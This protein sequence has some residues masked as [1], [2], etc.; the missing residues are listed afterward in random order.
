MMRLV[1]DGLSV[2]DANGRLL[3][4]P[5]D[6][7]VA[8]GS[9]VSLI[10]ESGAGKS[11]FCAAIAGLLPPELR[12]GG[13]IVIDGQDVTG[14]SP[15][16]RR[17]LWSRTVFLL[18]QE[19][20]TA[21]A[22]ARRLLTQ[23]AD[24]PRVH[25][26][27]ARSALATAAGRLLSRVG[28]SA[29]RAGDQ[30]PRMLSGGMAQR[31]AVATAL[32]APAGLV[33]VDEPTKGLDAP[34]RDRV[35]DNIRLLRDEG[36]AVVV[37]T[38]DLAMARDLGG[39]VLVLRDGVVVERGTAER[40]LTCPTHAFTRALLDAEPERWRR[41]TAPIGD[42]AITF[43]AVEVRSNPSGPALVRSLSFAVPKGAI[44]G[45][46]G[47]SGSGKTTIGNVAIGL[48]PPASGTVSRLAGESRRYQKLYQD[49]GAAFAAWRSIRATLADA[50][51]A[52]GLPRG[53]L[54][55]RFAP[56]AKR[57]RLSAALLDRRPGSVSGG[58]LQRLALARALLV[59]PVFLF[60]DEPTSR[61]DPLT[62]R[63]VA[64]M[65]TEVVADGVACLLASHDPA[66]I[67]ALASTVLTLDGNA[68]VVSAPPAPE[69]R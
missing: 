42:P 39:Q 41:T 47:P 49:P 33:L 25:G 66:L 55:D 15:R 12:I 27:V 63:E 37:V 38:H 3:L 60:A 24:M 44:V 56:L 34:L 22:P 61:L 59:R 5:L 1:T 68:A 10:G 69:P 17:A 18:P 14:L 7:A 40:I 19:P 23:I 52:V 30:R 4:A 29:E 51:T 43:D 58:E 32:G 50:L 21:L 16:E 31:A 8:A 48:I 2:S 57:L 53:S 35:R 65:L 11:L 36:R 20:W 26:G 54:D 9:T 64:L 45:L 62:Q 6:V 46:C 13:R 67:T 28:L